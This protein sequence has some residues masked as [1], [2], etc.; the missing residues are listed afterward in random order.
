MHLQQVIMGVVISI[1]VLIFGYIHFA[2]LNPQPTDRLPN[3]QQVARKTTSVDA[4][5]S[6]SGRVCIDIKGA[7]KRPGVY[8]LRKGSRVEEAIAA[9]GG[10]TNQADLNQVNLAKELLDQQIIQI[11]KIGEQL[12]Q[13]ASPSGSVSNGSDGDKV[14]LNTA[15]KEDLTKIDGVGDKKADKIL[16]YREQHGGFKSPDDLKNISGFGEKT[17]AKL[18]ERLAV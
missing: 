10:S 6:K 1:L 3:T 13:S 5:A 16:E 2:K 7:V 14:N 4:Q 11:P 15:T 9:A 8:H 17:V 12:A 18:R